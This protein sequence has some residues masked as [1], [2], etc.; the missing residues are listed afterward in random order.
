MDHVD[1]ASYFKRHFLD[2]NWGA[3]FCEHVPVLERLISLIT[4]DPSIS[5]RP[6]CSPPGALRDLK[7]GMRD[8]GTSKY[9]LHPSHCRPRRPTVHR[10]PSMCI[11]PS[12][13]ARPLTSKPALWQKAHHLM[14]LVGI[15]RTSA[16]QERA[17]HSAMPQG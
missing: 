13:G 8:P 17:S 16:S 5:C 12:G 10:R 11:I 2:F 4:P 14:S 3:D 6:E 9:A 15:S 1:M 7:K